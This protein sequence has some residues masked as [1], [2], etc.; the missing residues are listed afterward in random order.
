MIAGDFER[1][2]Y[3]MEQ[4]NQ[5]LTHKPPQSVVGVIGLTELMGAIKSD[6]VASCKPCV[7]KI[8]CV[9]CLYAKI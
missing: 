9:G 8:R 2:A 3:M 1:I 5:I 7:N 6:D 4:N